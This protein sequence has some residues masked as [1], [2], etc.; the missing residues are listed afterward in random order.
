ME[1][2]AL[3]RRFEK[4]SRFL[5]V[6]AGAVALLA[7]LPPAAG[8]DPVIAA[9][10]DIACD[11]AGT[12]NPCRQMETSDL[13]VGAGLTR[14][15]PVGDITQSGS[16][17]LANILALYDPSWGRVKSISSPVLGNHEGSGNGYFD[18]FNGVGASD[19][20][21]GP[22]G[23][24][25]YSF[26]V[27]GW[28]IVALNSNCTRPADT[29]NVVD[30]GVGSEQERW[31]RADLAAHP[32]S[33]TL[34][35][36]HH[37]RYSSGHDGSNTFTQP[38]WDALQD[39]QAEIVLSGH[40][41]N[42]ERFASLDR[43]G[44]PDPANGIRQFVVGTGGAFFT[45]IG[46][47]IANSEVSQNDT[48]GVLKL[49]LHPT[50]YDWQFVPEAGKTFTDSG[51]LLCHGLLAPPP[52]PDTIAPVIS[53]LTLS[54][55]RFSVASRAADARTV[56]R[57]SVFRYTL[58]EAA[59]VRFTIRRRS[60]GRN[61]AGRCRSTTRQNRGR[62]ACIFYRRVGRF[63]Q[64]GVAGGNARPFRGRIRNRRLNPGTFRASL[65]AFDAAGN[66][67]R[68]KRAGFQI[69]PKPPRRE[70]R[71]LPA[72]HRVGRSSASRVP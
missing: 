17:S 46:S 1:S 3:S 15:L 62:R 43:N 48:F 26:D 53:K 22:R 35:Y 7:A 52:H 13:L 31:L 10:G 49:T 57:R 24:G 59:T 23:K 11:P 40:S 72:S 45:G 54:P 61:V 9:A 29:T 2:V 47:T 4:V 32:A 50:R 71:Q 55:R 18:Y 51:S 41:H 25:W 38:F 28:H 67:S 66:R 56:S 16:A 36:W 44:A 37:P 5:A 39:A 34:A 8:A 21:A 33:C 69:R 64:S 30:C 68:P 14:V 12:T 65:V 20:P 70:G 6:G 27:G 60:K 19:G 63:V 42:Y 58:S